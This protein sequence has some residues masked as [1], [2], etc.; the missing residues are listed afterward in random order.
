MVQQA[1]RPVSGEKLQKTECRH[2]WIIEAPVG[3]VSRG[4]CR[5]CGDVRQFKNYI[6]AAPWGE[7]A[8]VPTST[9][10]HPELST[11]KDMDEP[12]EE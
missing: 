1:S 4:V 7:E 11:S 12:E 3:P 2:H 6:E 9:E 8:P 10:R 5:V